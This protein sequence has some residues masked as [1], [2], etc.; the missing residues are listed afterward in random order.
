MF[1]YQPSI[2]TKNTLFPNM[3]P[4]K[5]I[6]NMLLKLKLKREVLSV[7]VCILHLLSINTKEVST[8]KKFQK[9][10][11]TMLFNYSDGELKMDKNIGLEEIPGEHIGVNKG[12][13][14]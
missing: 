9:L 3:E 8:L 1:R 7:A 4:L 5:K 2:T 10:E 11:P 12:I 13:S 14:E 6:T